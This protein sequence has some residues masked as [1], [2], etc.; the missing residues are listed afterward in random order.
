MNPYRPAQR[1]RQTSPARLPAPDLPAAKGGVINPAWRKVLITIKPY[2]LMACGDEV[3]LRWHGLNPAAQPYRYEESRFVTERRVGRNVVFVVRE[4]HIAELDGGSLEVFYQVIGKQLPATLVSQ[5]LQLQIGDAPSQLLAA[6]AKDAVGGSL[7]PARVPEGT[8]LTVRPYFRMAT[9]DRLIL[10]ASREAKA[11][12]RD[13]LEIEAHTVGREVSFWIDHSQIA[14]HVGNALSLVYVVRQ[15]HSVR[16]AEPLSLNIGALVRPALKAPRIL[17]L[18]DGV[19]EVDELQSGLTVIIENAGTEAGELV[20]FQCNGNYAHVEE[21]EITEA[22]AGQALS[23]VVPGAYWQEQRGRSVTLFYQVERL[24]DVSQR[25]G[26]VTV[27]VRSM[28]QG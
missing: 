23:F 21:R 12:W 10:I 11:L 6:I 28:V 7:D 17:G 19:L 25:S 2:P 13:V 18:E 15:G 14:P 24:D 1:P 16:R 20:W 5:P 26:E 3:L 27:Q 22:T 4:P 9:G 8:A